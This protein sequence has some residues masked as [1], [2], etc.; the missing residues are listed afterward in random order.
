MERWCTPFEDVAPVWEFPSFPGQR[1]FPGAWWAV[2]LGDFVGF[3]SW[4]E[5]DQI[6]VM[7]QSPEVVAFSS[8]PFWLLWD[9]GDQQRRHAPDF[10]ARLRD[11][12]VS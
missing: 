11:G 5:R 4:L 1:S 9:D 6:M 8:Q 10:F 3:E 7:D 12:P 2:T